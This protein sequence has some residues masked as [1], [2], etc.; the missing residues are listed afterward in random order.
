[1]VPDYDKLI[2]LFDTPNWGKRLRSTSDIEMVN[3]KKRM[4]ELTPF[5]P[6]DAT[7]LRRAWHIR[8]NTYSIP[9]CPECKVKEIGW[10]NHKNK[11]GFFC[12]TR[13]AGKL[14]FVKNP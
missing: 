9:V 4:I 3:A 14:R 10:Q 1:M 13:C 2:A 11:Y 8:N 7:P 6:D 12:S 5:L